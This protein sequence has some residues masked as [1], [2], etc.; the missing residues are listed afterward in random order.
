MRSFIAAVMVI[1]A[2]IYK[3]GVEETFMRD[4]FGTEYAQYCH[5]VKRLIPKIW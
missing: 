3:S 2:W 5:V 4:H 1:L